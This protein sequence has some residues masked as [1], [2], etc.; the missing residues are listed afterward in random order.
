MQL[1]FAMRLRLNP[2]PLAFFNASF[3]PQAAVQPPHSLKTSA[4]QADHFQRSGA[5]PVVSPIKAA[6][7]SLEAEL[8]KEIKNLGLVPDSISIEAETNTCQVILPIGN[9]VH[10]LKEKIG[11]NPQ[12][13]LRYLLRQIQNLGNAKK[14]TRG[15]GGP[16]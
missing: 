2:A 10:V 16:W 5:K 8:A 11:R 9:K 14:N 3:S 1:R 12:E 4:L 13:S 7:T 15:S 6:T